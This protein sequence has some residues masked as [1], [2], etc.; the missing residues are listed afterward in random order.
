M[1]HPYPDYFLCGCGRNK[2]LKT[3]C[4][5]KPGFFIK[6]VW[7]TQES[8]IR[9]ETKIRATISPSP[10]LPP[11][12]LPCWE[13]F[14]DDR[15]S[16]KHGEVDAALLNNMF[17]PKGRWLVEQAKAF[18]MEGRLDPAFIYALD[19]TTVIAQCVFLLHLGTL[20]THFS[21]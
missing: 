21:V 17:A 9:P 6:E 11:A 14:W 18:G 16:R 20:L 7:C 2:T 10:G 19:A 15:A 8:W 4:G 1:I 12:L 3:C 5:K 13:A